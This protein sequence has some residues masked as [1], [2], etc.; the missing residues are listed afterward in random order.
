MKNVPIRLLSCLL[1]LVMALGCVSLLSGCGESS[2]EVLMQAGNQTISTGVFQL[3]LSRV[4]GNLSRSGYKVD[5]ASFW[6]TVIDSDGTVYGEYMLQ[7]ALMDAKRYLAAAVIFE[8]EGLSLPKATLD[9]IETEIT[10]FIDYDANGSKSSF[11][12]LL[13]T[14]GANITALRELY[15][16]EAKATALKNHLYGTDASKVAANVKQEYL[17]E[18]VVCFKQILF[19][20]YYEKYETD[21]YGEHVYYKVGSNNARVNNIA[22]DSTNGTAKMDEDGKDVIKDANGDIVYY[23]ADGHISYDTVN[24]QR[25]PLYDEDGD[26]QVGKYTDAEKKAHEEQA[27]N[28]MTTLKTGD[29]TAFESLISECVAAEDDAIMTDNEYCFLY[30]TGDNNED[31]LNDLADVLEPMKEGEVYLLSSEYGYAI[32]MKYP[33]VEDAYSQTDYT[34]WFSDFNSRVTAQLFQTKCDS[35]LNDVTVD[36]EQFAALPSMKEIGTNFYY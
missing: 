13:S 30:T 24:G 9:A 19:R 17:E 20:N 36:N 12:S 1:A 28:M 27:R 15:I 34:E 3:M 32:L 16:L 21:I 33:M 25:A 5:D 31:Y 18:N 2:G 7:R 14:Y 29:Y 35:R 6:E 26:V 8:E 22:Y 10:E 11:N 4:K 23:T